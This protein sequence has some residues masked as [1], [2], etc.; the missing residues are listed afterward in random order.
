MWE[1]IR[2]N[3]R[4]RVPNPNVISYTFP[5]ILYPNPKLGLGC[6][7]AWES[8]RYNIRVGVPNPNVISYTFPHIFCLLSK[9]ITI[10]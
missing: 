5:H 10:T 3:I 6:K 7:N 8:I 2:Y 9:Y 1:S 4:V